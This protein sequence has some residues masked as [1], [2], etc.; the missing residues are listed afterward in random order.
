M[1]LAIFIFLTISVFINKILSFYV[2]GNPLPFGWWEEP[3]KS[4]VVI[5]GTRCIFV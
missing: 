4:E 3:C 1:V 2:G 5:L